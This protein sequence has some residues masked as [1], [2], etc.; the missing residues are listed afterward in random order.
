MP[1]PS[2]PSGCARLRPSP[3]EPSFS[4]V[5]T[6]VTITA[7]TVFNLAPV[8][9]NQGAPVFPW[10]HGLLARFRPR[11]AAAVEGGPRSVDLERSRRDLGRSQWPQAGRRAGSGRQSVLPSQQGVA[12]L[13]LARRS[14]NGM[15]RAARRERQAGAVPTKGP[16]RLVVSRGER[17]GDMQIVETYASGS[18]SGTPAGSKCRRFRVATTWP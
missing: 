1:P 15:G 13:S 12:A 8:F 4:P 14:E 11:L 16:G 17:R 6:P 18:T 5:E 3:P 10:L 2:L 9:D 7:G